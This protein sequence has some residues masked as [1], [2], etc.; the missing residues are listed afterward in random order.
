MTLRDARRYLHETS[1]AYPNHLVPV[2]KE[3]WPQMDLKFPPVQ[4]WRSRALVVQIYARQDGGTRV[5]VNRAELEAEHKWKD[6]LTWDDLQ[7]VKGEIGFGDAWAVEIFPPENSVVNVAN[8]RH[9]WIIS[10][11]PAFAWKRD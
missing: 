9:L 2:A 3:K 11:A 10:E 8:I 6:G 5:S 1:K 4:V 7:R